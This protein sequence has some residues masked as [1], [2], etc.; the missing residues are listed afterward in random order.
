MVSFV[1]FFCLGLPVI[2]IMTIAFLICSI[3]A[4]SGIKRRLY[5]NKY[6]EL[7][8]E[9][10]RASIYCPYCGKKYPGSVTECPCCRA[11]KQTAKEITLNP[12]MFDNHPLVL[13]MYASAT[14]RA[15]TVAILLIIVGLSMISCMAMLS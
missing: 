12:D 4:A 8:L 15:N 10:K 6:Q 7:A 14:K 11:I 2:L 9:A 1:A 5:E 13:E 3:P